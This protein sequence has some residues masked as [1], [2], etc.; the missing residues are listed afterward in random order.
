MSSPIIWE[1]YLLVS[2]SGIKQNPGRPHRWRTSAKAVK[3]KP[4]TR[5]DEV[6]VKVRVELPVEL[7]VRPQLEARISVSADAVSPQ[8]VT[9]DIAKEIEKAVLQGTGFDLKILN[10]EEE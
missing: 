5:P 8:V 2:V 3:T 7:F 6:A 1:G 4:G 9:V 10:A